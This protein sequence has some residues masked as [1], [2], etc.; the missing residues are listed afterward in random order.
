MKRIVLSFIFLL[1]V[2]CCLADEPKS[3][4][5]IFIGTISVNG[6]DVPAP[7]LVR[8]KKKER[9]EVWL[10]T[11]VYGEPL[12]DTT[13]VG[14]V[15]IPQAVWDPEGNCYL[16]RGICRQAF[17][18]CRHLT[19]VVINDSTQMIGD[20]SFLGCESLRKIVLPPALLSIYPCAFRGCSRLRV[21]QLRSKKNPY[22]YSDIFDSQ[23]VDFGTLFIPAGTTSIY[24]DSQVWGVFR[25]RLESIE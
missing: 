8:Y 10:G 25:H 1:N 16:V 2:G 23:T 6:K 12:I 13:T 3:E 5:T 19:E 24:C 18:H 4:K 15:V 22:I 17:A 11:G 7:Y 20:Q 9:N 14:R 21:V